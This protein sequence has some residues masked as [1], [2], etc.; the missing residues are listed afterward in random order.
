M[1]KR[2]SIYVLILVL[3]IVFA[4]CNTKH[5]NE[6]SFEPLT[7]EQIQEIRE[8]W[9]TLGLGTLSLSALTSDKVYYGTHGDC[10]A[11][12]Y[13]P[14][15]FILMKKTLEV[16]GVTIEIATE[17][18]IYIYRNGAFLKLEDAYREEWLSKE[19]VEA[20]AQHHM[21]VRLI[22]SN[23]PLFLKD[24]PTVQTVSVSDRYT[25][26][27]VFRLEDSKSIRQ[28]EYAFNN[29]SYDSAA[30]EVMDISLNYTIT[31]EDFG[32]MLEIEFSESSTYCRIDDKPY[33]LPDTFH[34][35]IMEYIENHN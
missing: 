3:V 35:L 4:G 16:A 22:F 9:R 31:F 19:N 17:C 6:S 7:S 33:L 28:L 27:L 5:S 14:D 20:I 29:W 34:Q 18:E 2:S 12:F 10:V 21:D 1:I 13:E 32:K 30:T 24:Y 23:N 11:I 26:E 15:D 25:N 8:D